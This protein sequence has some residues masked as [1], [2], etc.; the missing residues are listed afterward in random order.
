MPKKVLDSSVA[1]GLALLGCGR[2]NVSPMD[3]MPS[4]ADWVALSSGSR[5]TLI[6]SRDAS[7]QGSLVVTG[8]NGN[9]I[10]IDVRPAKGSLYTLSDTNIL[11]TST[12]K[13]V[14]LQLPVRCRDK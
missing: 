13:Q 7:G 10:A 14:L 4:P 11:Y 1:S 9:L 8:V 2:G 5:L 3:R 12:Y 6:R